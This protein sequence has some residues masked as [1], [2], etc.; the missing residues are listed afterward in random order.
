MDN[1]L[2][3]KQTPMALFQANLGKYEQTV[4]DL[5]GTKYGIAPQEFMVKV[6]N[7][8]KKT[9]ELLKCT[10]QSLFGSIL[11]FA[12]IGLP[13][14]Y[15]EGFGYILTFSIKGNMCLNFGIVSIT[16]L[17]L[18]TSLLEQSNPQI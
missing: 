7:A 1:Q 12:E 14:N 18:L 9:P 17:A 2:E 15:P 16:L 6:L 10:P 4:V 3:V 8:V 13:F 11:Y 5:L